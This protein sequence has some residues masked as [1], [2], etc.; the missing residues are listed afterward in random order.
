[1]PID[2]GERMSLFDLGA[3]IAELSKLLGVRVDVA[4][5]DAPPDTMRQRGLR[6]AAPV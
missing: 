4:T 5:P 2:S 6:D 3:I 1:M